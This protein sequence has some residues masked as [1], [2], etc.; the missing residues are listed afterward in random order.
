MTDRHT[1]DTDEQT[2]RHKDRSPDT[3]NSDTTRPVG[4]QTQS[5]I[6]RG[7][8]T[9]NILPK[10]V[11]LKKKKS[12]SYIQHTSEGEKKSHKDNITQGDNQTSSSGL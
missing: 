4:R 2:D 10:N 3:C 12:N 9:V 8:Q 1:V 5:H 6:A 7:R 11:E